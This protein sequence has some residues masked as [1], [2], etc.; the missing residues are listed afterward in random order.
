MFRALVGES[1][2]Q[3]VKRVRLELAVAMISATTFSGTKASSL[4]DIALVCGFSSSSDFSRS[5]KQR[6]GVTPSA[7]GV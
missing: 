5:F 7:F 2:N 3:F 6:Y 1:L 4:T